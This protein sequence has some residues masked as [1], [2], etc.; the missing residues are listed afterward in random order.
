MVENFFS[1][2][3]Y[4]FL[5]GSSVGVVGY[6][7][8][9]GGGIILVPILSF[10][11]LSMHE[12]IATSLVV[13]V[14]NSGAVSI[15]KLKDHS[16]LLPITGILELSGILGA[17]IGGLAAQGLQSSSLKIVF[18]FFTLFMA[19]LIWRRANDKTEDISQVTSDIS[20]FGKN[21]P[22][23]GN[24]TSNPYL[25]ILGF[26]GGSLSALL[27]IGAGAMMVPALNTLLRVP[28]RMAAATSSY[29]S[30]V[31]AL[32]GA[33]VLFPY[34]RFE[35]VAILIISVRLGTIFAHARLG[36]IESASLKRLFAGL[37]FII[38]IKMWF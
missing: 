32:V 11:G 16:I 2:F 30:G 13:I 21:C 4:F 26:G 5:I 14:F 27:G 33:V 31:F 15:E 17:A 19:I 38:S 29:I 12:S 24:H 6:L 18:S 3:L 7:F 28:F 8:G 37:L 23:E 20:D 25:W 22:Q 10:F 34:I 1:Y 35:T 9:L 36:K